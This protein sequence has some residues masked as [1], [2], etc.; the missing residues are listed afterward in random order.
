[1]G[2]EAKLVYYYPTLFLP[3]LIFSFVFIYFI[4]KRGDLLSTRAGKIGARILM[5]YGVIGGVGFFGIRRI[6][7]AMLGG[8]ADFYIATA[9]RSFFVAAIP[10]V[11]FYFFLSL[12]GKQTRKI[13]PSLISIIIILHTEMSIVYFISGGIWGME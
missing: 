6:T 7:H 12:F 11:I 13:W 1:M 4:R 5:A 3:A 8:G 2:Y 10:C 9:G